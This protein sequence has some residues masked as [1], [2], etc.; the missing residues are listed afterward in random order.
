MTTLTDGIL[1]KL[2]TSK[3]GAYATVMKT[4]AMT[5]C[6]TAAEYGCSAWARSAHAKQANVTRNEA[7]RLVTECLKPTAIE[8]TF[9][10]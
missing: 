2:T 4:T 5:L 10:Y 7:C 9:S 3:W 8:K 1:K 6:F